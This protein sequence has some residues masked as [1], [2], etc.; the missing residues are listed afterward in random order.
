MAGS[1]NEFNIKIKLSGTVF[2]PFKVKLTDTVF[3]LKQQLASQEGIEAGNISLHGKYSDNSKTFA[4]LGLTQDENIFGMV[5][6]NKKGG[7]TR[8]RKLR[9]TRRHYYV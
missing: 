9:K 6:F 5:R 3:S 2:G 8:R 1:A 7:K 4:E